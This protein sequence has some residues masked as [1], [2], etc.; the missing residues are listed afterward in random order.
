MALATP[1]I[2]ALTLADAFL[3]LVVASAVLGVF[4]L[5]AGA[6]VGFQYAAEVSYPV[7]ESLSQGVIL[8]AGQVSGVLFIVGVNVLGVTPMMWLFVGLMAV[9]LAI[10]V[11]LRESPRILV[12]GRDDAG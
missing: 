4:L 6:P 8:L 12:A 9:A 3:P 5:G 2:A 7:A 10:A 1:A 11:A